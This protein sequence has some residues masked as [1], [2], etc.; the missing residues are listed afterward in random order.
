[1]ILQ[2]LSM[3]ETLITFQQQ[4]ASGLVSTAVCWE[5]GVPGKGVSALGQASPVAC[6][7]HLFHLVVPEL[8]P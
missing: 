1:M 3:N 7:V 8:Y 5:D 6:P 4:A 2:I